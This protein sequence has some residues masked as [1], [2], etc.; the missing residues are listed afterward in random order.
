MATTPRRFVTCPDCG[1]PNVPSQTQSQRCV[2]CS[3]VYCMIREQSHKKRQLMVDPA[4]PPLVERNLMTTLHVQN[5]DE[6][7]RATLIRTCSNSICRQPSGNEYYCVYCRNYRRNP[8][9]PLP[10]A[11]AIVAIAAAAPATSHKKLRL[12]DLTGVADKELACVICLEDIPANIERVYYCDCQALICSSCETTPN[13][14]RLTKCP[15]CRKDY[16][17][18]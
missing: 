8:A 12:C 2:L 17:F 1:D 13:V 18:V 16:C 11:L 4:I 5:A 14:K 9:R 3:E 10:E 6:L 15:N 7:Q